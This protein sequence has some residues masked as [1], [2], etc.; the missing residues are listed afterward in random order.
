MFNIDRQGFTLIEVI[1]SVAI[2]A[3]VL[4]ASGVNWRAQRGINLNLA[5]H[6]LAGDIRQMQSLTMG[7]RPLPD[8]TLPMG[9]WGI[10]WRINN[11]NNRRGYRLWADS[12]DGSSICEDN[13]DHLWSVNEI[14]RSRSLPP[15]VY[16]DRIHLITD[17]GGTVNLTSTSSWG[18]NVVFEPPDPQVWIVRQL[19]THFGVTT[20]KAIKI[21]LSDGAQTRIVKVNKFGLVDVY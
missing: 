5:A 10:N 18:V 3:L 6:Q 2:I 13:C 15:D 14:V 21:Y 7:L 16:I 17:S 11:D 1:V 9:G 12:R 8:G 19:N 4:A 20:Y